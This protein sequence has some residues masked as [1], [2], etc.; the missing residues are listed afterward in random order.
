MGYTSTL[1]VF[2][3]PP[4]G[5]LHYLESSYYRLFEKE[6]MQ[7]TLSLFRSVVSQNGLLEDPSQTANREPPSC[8]PL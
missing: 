8:K 2:L 6:S 4:A 5:R 1:A 3:Y 7:S